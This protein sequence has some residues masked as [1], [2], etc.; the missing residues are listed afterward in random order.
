MSVRI[1]EVIFAD[2]Y[3]NPEI[4][5]GCTYR[6]LVVTIYGINMLKIIIPGDLGKGGIVHGPTRAW[7]LQV[8]RRLQESWSLQDV[9]LHRFKHVKAHINFPIRKPIAGIQTYML[10]VKSRGTVYTALCIQKPEISKY[11]HKTCNKTIL[12]LSFP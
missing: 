1:Q 8:Q 5:H 6:W 7:A 9:I 10:Q 11:P 2:Y 4:L 3:Q 12:R